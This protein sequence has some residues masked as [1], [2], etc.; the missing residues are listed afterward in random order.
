[1]N[2]EELANEIDRILEILRTLDPTSP[3]YTTAAK[4]YHEMMS[5]LHEELEECDSE[6]DHKLK[7]EL[8]K[9]RFEQSKIEE[10]NRSKEAKR[11]A[12]LNLAELGIKIGGVLAAI[13]VTGSLEETTILSKNGFSLVRTLLPKA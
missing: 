12:I 4:N 8:D 5:T 11:E 3:A 9:A 1:M 6:L 13:I 10:A 7:R 2:Q